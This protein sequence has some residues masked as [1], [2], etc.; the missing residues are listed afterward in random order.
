MNILSEKLIYTT[1]ERSQSGA[2][3]GLEARPTRL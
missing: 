2:A 3:G 1:V